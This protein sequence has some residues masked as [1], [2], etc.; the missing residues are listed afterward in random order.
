MLAA[1]FL[2][3]L[4]A[5]AEQLAG[6]AVGARHRP[7]FERTVRL[8]VGWGF[9]VGAAASVAFF[10]AGPLLID[11]MTTS[12]EVRQTARTYLPLAALFPVVGEAR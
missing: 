12:A 7:A 2:D 1:N 3:G 8:T 9:A 6:R 10:L 11:L 4:A 5:A